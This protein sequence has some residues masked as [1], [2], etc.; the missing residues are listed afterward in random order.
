MNIYQKKLWE[1]YL[2]EWEK[3]P[4]EKWGIKKWDCVDHRWVLKHYNPEEFI[5][6]IKNY[7]DF[8]QKWGN[9]NNLDNDYFN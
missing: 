5:F 7:L 3:N 1:I 8:F 9:I 2:S 4:D 6:R